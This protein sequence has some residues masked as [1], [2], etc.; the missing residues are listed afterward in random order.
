MQRIMSLSGW[1]LFLVSAAY[2]AAG[3]GTRW[4]IGRYCMPRTIVADQEK[5]RLDRAGE[6]SS[7]TS[8]AAATGEEEVML[9]LVGLLGLSLMAAAIAVRRYLRAART[10]QEAYDRQ[11]REPERRT[12][13]D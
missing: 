3:Y 13:S 10:Y 9:V 4:E 1:V 6:R 5:G 7:S 11:L 2:V 8:G 12:T